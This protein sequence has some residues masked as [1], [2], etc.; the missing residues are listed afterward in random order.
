MGVA[1]ALQHKLK[2]LVQHSPDGEH[3]NERP[4]R[5][6]PF[7]PL[8]TDKPVKPV[9]RLQKQQKPFWLRPKV[10]LPLQV[11]AVVARVLQQVVKKQNVVTRRAVV[12]RLKKMARRVQLQLLDARQKV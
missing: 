9:A 11:A 6:L 12:Q 1:I 7:T 4:R 8:R 3:V 5:H 2:P 10:A